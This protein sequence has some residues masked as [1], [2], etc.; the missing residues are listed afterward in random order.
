M[1]KYNLLRIKNKYLILY[2]NFQLSSQGDKGYMKLKKG[3]TCGICF[4]GY[5]PG[6]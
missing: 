6:F 1:G 3:N 4:R 5:K 2:I